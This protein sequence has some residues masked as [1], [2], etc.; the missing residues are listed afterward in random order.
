MPTGTRRAVSMF[1]DG[2]ASDA[3]AAAARR[4]GFVQRTSKLPGKRLLARVTFGAW[5]DATTTGA[6]W[7][8]QVTHWDEQVAVSP[9]AIHPR[10]HPRARACLQDMLRHALAKVHAVD[11]VC[12]DGRFT[13]CPTVS[14]ADRPGFAR[15]DS[16]HALLSGSGGSAATAGANLQ[17]VW[18]YTN[19]V[20]GQVALPPGNLPAQRDGDTVGAFAPTGVLLLVDLGSVKSNA[21]ACRAAAGA[22][23]CRRLQQQTTR[24]HTASGQGQPLALA[25]WRTTVAGAS[26]EPAMV[27]GAQ[28]PGA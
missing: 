6:P 26:I 22:S 18:D 11:H 25:S 14:L 3:I 4:T 19:S 13:D 2:F 15:P 5:R 7:A 10:L 9:E 16:G 28:E 17:A 23:V 1:T 21:W 12:P 27:L 20:G 8:A 24:V